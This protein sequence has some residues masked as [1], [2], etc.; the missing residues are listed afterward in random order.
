M[1]SSDAVLKRC[2][3]PFHLL[4]L[5]YSDHA[6]HGYDDTVRYNIEENERLRH[7]M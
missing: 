3:S 1:R 7:N 2:S 6:L 4:E 5:E